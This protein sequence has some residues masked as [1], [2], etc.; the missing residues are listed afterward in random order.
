MSDDRFYVYAIEYETGVVAYIGKGSGS[1]LRTQERRFGLK[2]R[3]LKTFKS[4]KAAY[5][6]ERRMIGELKPEMNRNPGGNGSRAQI[7]RRRREAWEID[8][9]R[10]GTRRYAARALLRFGDVAL[11][12]YLAPESIQQLKQVAC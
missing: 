5:A 12:R 8:M 6:Y 11:R 1:R 9:E 2:G 7:V 10:V 3:K 4:E